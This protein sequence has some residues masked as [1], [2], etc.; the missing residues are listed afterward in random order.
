M[1][2][3]LPPLVRYLRYLR[4]YQLHLATSYVIGIGLSIVASGLG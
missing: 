1:G 2:G 4:Y 3:G